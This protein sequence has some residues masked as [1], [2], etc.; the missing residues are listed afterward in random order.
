MNKTSLTV[1]LFVLVGLGIM[2]YLAM[3]VDDEGKMFSTGGD[4]NPYWVR[5]RSAEGLRVNDPVEVAGLKAGRIQKIGI[6]DEGRMI[7]VDFS[8]ET[9]FKL[10][11]SSKIMIG[12]NSILGGKRLKITLPE[13]VP[14]KALAKGAEMTNTE[15]ADLIASIGGAF[16]KISALIDDNRDNVKDLF[17]N[18]KETTD[19]LNKSDAT[20]GKLINDEEMG[21]QL[22]DSFA[23]IKDITEQLKTDITGDEGTLSKLL[24]DKETSEKFTS[25]VDSADSVMK[26]VREITD[27][28]NN[29]EHK[30]LVSR[31][32]NDEELGKKAEDM[33]G[34]INDAFAEI[35][36]IVKE[37]ADTM[38]ANITDAFEEIKTI[39]AKVSSGEGTLGQVVMKDDI[40]DNLNKLLIGAGDA[41][42]DA[43][44]QAPITSFGTAILG[45]LQ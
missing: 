33:I 5:F 35:K 44:E 20:I 15:E 1:G 27:K 12:Q 10:Y 32:I 42:E 18:L 2:F 8:L 29:P 13:G 24:R 9:R 43:R 11:P 16:R 39:A 31:L 22:K 26:N 34:N 37:K 25:I 4:S 45:P 21:N 41:V 30:G 38:I 6:D 17:A 40:A 14:G 3:K 23:N 36:K 19:K 7:R 28:V